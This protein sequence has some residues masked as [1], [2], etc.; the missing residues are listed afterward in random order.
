MNLLRYKPGRQPGKPSVVAIGNFDGVHP[1]HREL[2]RQSLEI[3]RT[4]GLEHLICTFE[5]SPNQWFERSETRLNN[6]R[7]KVFLL[8]SLGVR[9]LVLVHFR[10][11]F[12][13]LSASDFIRE[14][15]LRDMNMRHLVTGE[16][17]K[18]GKDRSGDRHKLLEAAKEYDFGYRTVKD[19]PNE[20]ERISST[21]IRNLLAAGQI[22]EANQL[23]GF[24]YSFCAR[25]ITGSGIG[26]KML[27]TATANLN[28]KQFIPPLRGVF[29]CMATLANGEKKKAVVNCG[30][31]PTLNRK[32]RLSLEA[33]LPDYEGN[34]YGQVL[35]LEFLAYLRSEQKF[36]DLTAL[37]RQIHKDKILAL[38][39]LNRL[40]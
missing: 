22:T 39:T 4:S 7:T 32:H 25:V 1:G 30:V 15:L 12:C 21:Q 18:F 36:A 8:K 17:F 20:R 31:K 33:H 16:D 10:R 28:L 11:P 27:G 23:L 14:F 9:K 26:K 35:R 5:P 13:D 40:S 6:L 29:A 3:A 19:F 24:P 38:K 2:I 34:L 37:K